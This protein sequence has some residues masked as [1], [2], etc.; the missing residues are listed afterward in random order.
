MPRLSKAAV[1]SKLRTPFVGS[2]PMP[3]AAAAASAM[4]WNSPGVKSAPPV[5]SPPAARVTEAV[6]PAGRGPPE[7][8]TVKVALSAAS[9]AMA[10]L[11]TATERLTLATSSAPISRPSKRRVSISRRMSVPSRPG[12]LSLTWIA[13][14]S[15]TCSS[16]C[17]RAPLKAATSAPPWPPFRLSLPPPPKSRS[18]PG[19]PEIRSFPGP[20]VSASLPSSP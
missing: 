16:Y 6:L 1:S 10:A 8:L 17:S 14:S 2:K 15:S 19:P 18:S 3:L 20:P 5:A 9:S 13:P 11:S 4:A 7:S 12:T